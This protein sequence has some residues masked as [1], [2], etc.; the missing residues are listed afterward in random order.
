LRRDVRAHG[1]CPGKIQFGA[2]FVVPRSKIED[3]APAQ[4]PVCAGTSVAFC[5]DADRLAK[6][7]VVFAPRVLPSALCNLLGHDVEKGLIPHDMELPG[8]MVQDI[9]LRNGRAY[10]GLIG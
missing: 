9:C 2:A 7:L 1:S 4:R 10:F 8:K 5:G 6:F 3:G